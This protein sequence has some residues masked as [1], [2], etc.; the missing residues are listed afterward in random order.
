MKTIVTF[1]LLS[2]IHSLFSQE[3]SLKVDG[4]N[5]TAFCR[6]VSGTTILGGKPT[7]N[8][9]LAPY[10][11]K[12]SWT[13]FDYDDSTYEIHD[14]LINSD[15][16]ANPFFFNGKLTDDDIIKFYVNVTDADNNK[17]F[18]SITITISAAEFTTKLLINPR[19][20][21]GDTFRMVAKNIVYGFRPLKYEWTPVYNLSCFDCE[22]PLAWPHKDTIYKVYVTD[23]IGCTGMDHIYVTVNPV[24]VVP[25]NLKPDYKIINNPIDAKSKIKFDFNIESARLKILTI[26]GRILYDRRVTS[27]ILPIGEIIKKPGYYIL[28]I[29][30]NDKII[31]SCK[32]IRD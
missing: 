19:I 7:A 15:T 1:I 9:G 17:G 4:G 14:S 20:T 27:N 12:W 30:K 3:N 29:E 23:S 2:S 32:I 8:N 18:D 26:D 25:L 11:Y 24:S 5:D 10:K 28:N 13:V 22:K 31:S 21:A 6:K 16:I